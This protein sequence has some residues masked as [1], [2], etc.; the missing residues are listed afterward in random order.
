MKSHTYKH[1]ESYEKYIASVVKITVE[2]VTRVK[3]NCCGCN[4]DIGI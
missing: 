3:H 2:N 1:Y 4:I